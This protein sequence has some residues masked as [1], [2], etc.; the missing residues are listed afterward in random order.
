M[1]P[2]CPETDPELVA[3]VS[4]LAAVITFAANV[5]SWGGRLSKWIVSAQRLFS[6]L[7]SRWF[8][9]RG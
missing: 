4:L 3:A 2:K 9:S 8:A 6:G 1:M 5:L 7:Y